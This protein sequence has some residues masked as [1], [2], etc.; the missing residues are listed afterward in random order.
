LSLSRISHSLVSFETVM[1]VLSCMLTILANLCVISLLL[2]LQG[3]SYKNW[4][5]PYKG[6]A[7]FVLL[8]TD[9][10]IAGNQAV[11]PSWSVSIFVPHFSKPAWMNSTRLKLRSR[12]GDWSQRYASWRKGRQ[13]RIITTRL[14]GRLV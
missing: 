7:V 12:D 14:T 5:D 6:D 1:V 2:W 13:P 4:F 10:I 3:S 9:T 11:W 8:Q